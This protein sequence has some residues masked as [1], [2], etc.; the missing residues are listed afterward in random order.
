MLWSAPSK[1]FSDLPE[2]ATSLPQTAAIR[3]ADPGIKVS[4]GRGLKLSLSSSDD[5]SPD[6]TA[7]RDTFMNAKGQSNTAAINAATLR[8]PIPINA[9]DFKQFMAL[10]PVFWL[11]IWQ[12]L[13]MT[14]HRVPSFKDRGFSFFSGCVDFDLSFMIRLHV[15]A[16][17]STARREKCHF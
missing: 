7:R 14:D 15:R 16:A 9:I 6:F 8:T 3:S 13:H 2:N 4:H 10:L 11:S 17:G 5:F 12:M 1:R